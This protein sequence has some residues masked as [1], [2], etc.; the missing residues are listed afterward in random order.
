MGLK[1]IF[2]FKR[3]RNEPA[4]PSA[5]LISEQELSE[6]WA[7]CPSCKTTIYTTEL[8]ANSMVC[9]KCEYHFRISSYERIEQLIDADTWEEINGSIRPSD[10]LKFVDLKPY[11]QSL[12]SAKKRSGATEA[13]VTG[14]GKINGC[15]TALG[16]ME[17]GFMGGSMGSVVG[18]RIARLCEMAID[19]KLPVVL[20]STSGGARMHEGL[21]SL[22]QMAKTSAVLAELKKSKLLF[23][24]VLT[25][26]TYGGVSASFA[27]L[28]DII[29]AEPRAKIGFAGPRVIEE[30]IRQK[31]PKDF[32]TSEY[33]LEH[34]QIDLVVHRNKLKQQLSQLIKLHN[35]QPIKTSANKVLSSVQ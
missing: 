20:I 32:Q 6:L 12:E 8:K 34:G 18:E 17:F 21:L 23:I 24:S 29:I 3:K 35:V 5:E 16:V 2:K 14:I 28:G 31:L 19:K 26:P 4:K 1:D 15:E 10:P 27:M 30:T 13:I 33:L 22:M 7:Q 9:H 11:V 25:D